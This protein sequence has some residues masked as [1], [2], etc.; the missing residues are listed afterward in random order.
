METLQAFDGLAHFEERF[1]IVGESCHWLDHKNC[2]GESCAQ[3][4]LCHGPHRVF[5]SQSRN[6]K[7]HTSC[8]LF[9]WHVLFVSFTY[10]NKAIKL[11]F[12]KTVHRIHD[13]FFSFL[14]WLGY[15][16]WDNGGDDLSEIEKGYHPR[17]INVTKLL[18][19][20]SVNHLQH[21]LKVVM[22]EPC[23]VLI[24]SA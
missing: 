4:A 8:F 16:I 24:S 9:L 22:I 13:L 3:N 10:D 7:K 1:K 6:T 11:I 2:N 19:V 17:E 20:I 23:R 14:Q 21:I 15:E 12:R 5:P 18:R